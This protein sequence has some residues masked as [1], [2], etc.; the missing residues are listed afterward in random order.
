M[1]LLAVSLLSPLAAG[2]QQLGRLFFTPDQR[3]A[4]D[5]RRRAG[6]QDRAA[7]LAISPSTRV[8]GV[9]VRSQGKSTIWLDGTAIPDGV[10]PDG[11]RVRRDS[12]PTRVR[13]GVGEQGGYV[14]VRVGEQVDRA[15]GDIKD[16]IG[17]GELKVQRHDSPSR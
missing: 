2:A 6:V 10:R 13:I 17:S 3:E 16:P 4:L 1:I 5:A 9:V 7:P 12:D 15:S 14:N 8:D 11:I